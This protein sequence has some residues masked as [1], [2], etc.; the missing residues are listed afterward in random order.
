MRLTANPG[1]WNRRRGPRLQE[2]VLRNDLPRD[3]ALG[4]VCDAEGEV[5][6]LTGILPAEA[7]RV[8]GSAHAQLVAADEVRV[9]VGII[10]RDA[11][12]VPLADRRARRALNL[13]VDRTRLV[14]EAFRGYAQ[15][16]SGLIPPAPATLAHRAPDRLR[17]YPHDPARAAALWRD[18]GAGSGSGLALRIA[19]PEHLAP[20]AGRVA[21]DLE[22]ALGLRTELT[23]LDP[24]EQAAT[25]R[26]L[27]E[28]VRPR[29]W[30]VLL[31]EHV[32]Q[33]VDAP[34]HELHRGFAGADGEY[35]AG[36]EVPELD[37]RLARLVAAISPAKQVLASAQIDRLV[38]AE[39]L[40]LF[41]CSPQKLYAVNREVRF[42]AYA[43]SFELAETEVTRRHWSR[44]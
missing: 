11:T 33:E 26:A 14:E 42:K 9:L 7:A 34:P 44:R 4:L 6:L 2:V 13:A 8:E 20:A 27:A 22:A 19:A 5:D 12:D 25:R 15:P 35:R 32:A 10:D 39:A 28:R 37:R 24:A 23:L 17:P 21:A 16:L 1:Y 29:P 30:H 38:R 41:L 31:W 36:P 43:T 40:A 18:A 3:E